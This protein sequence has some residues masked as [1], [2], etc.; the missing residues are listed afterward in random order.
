[1]VKNLALLLL[2]GESSEPILMEAI[3]V[4]NEYCCHLTGL[5]S[6]FVFYV[7]IS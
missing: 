5:T 4:T 6:G 3:F 2:W 1:M 7:D